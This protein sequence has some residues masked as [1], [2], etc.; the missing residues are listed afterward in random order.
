MKD[1]DLDIIRRKIDMIDWEIIQLLNQRMEIS[2]RSRKL[3]RQI[4]DPD[5]ERQIL[6]NVK[7]YSYSLI[8]PEFSEGIYR[9][10]MEESKNVQEK[11]LTLIGFRV[12]T[13]LTARPLPLRMILL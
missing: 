6:E 13:A 2:V 5:R 10:I 1:D 12:N 3:K 9:Q 8:K 11:D 7:R 4:L